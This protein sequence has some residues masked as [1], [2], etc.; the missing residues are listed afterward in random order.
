MSIQE[1]IRISLFLKIVGIFDTTTTNHHTFTDY[2]QYNYGSRKET[3]RATVKRA[4][5]LLSCPLPPPAVLE[6]L[7]RQRLEKK[8]K[9]KRENIFFH[10]KLLKNFYLVKQCFLNSNLLND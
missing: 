2:F 7:F 4:L 3:A 10:L 9:K 5:P 1:K 8:R 6:C